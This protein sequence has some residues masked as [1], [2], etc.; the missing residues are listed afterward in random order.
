[1]ADRLASMTG[2]WQVPSFNVDKMLPF[3]FSF[4]HFGLFSSAHKASLV[5]VLSK[6][7]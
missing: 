3:T 6:T 4:F 5:Y 1:L 2:I 7:T